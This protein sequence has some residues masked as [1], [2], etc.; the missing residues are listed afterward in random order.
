[1]HTTPG[2]AKVESASEKLHALNPH[3]ELIVH[4]ERL[5]S[6]N[7]LAILQNYDVIVDGSD[8]FPTRYLV[9]DACVLLQ[10]PDV[11]GSVLGFEGQV[12]IFAPGGPCYRCLYETPPPPGT[13]ASCAEAGIFPT[14]AGLVGLL[15][16]NEALKLLVGI[17]PTLKGRLLMIDAR[18]LSFSEIALRRNPD[19]AVCGEHPTITELIDYEEFCGRQ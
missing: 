4:P 12:T 8:N 11:H 9:N 10:K 19:C 13:V 17:E 16:A 15:Q 14:V 3:V 1:V 5:T 2:R 6:H 7:A 18:A